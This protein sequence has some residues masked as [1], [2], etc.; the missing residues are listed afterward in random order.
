M[1]ASEANTELGKFMSRAVNDGVIKNKL[2][3]EHLLGLLESHKLQLV[4]WRAAQLAALAQANEIKIELPNGIK[5]PP[6]T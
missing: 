6:R 2:P 4:A 3:F 5:I 1:N